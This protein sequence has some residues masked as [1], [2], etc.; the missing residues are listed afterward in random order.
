V[1][2][3]E[4]LPSDHDEWLR[5]RLL[6]WPEDSYEA[7][8]EQMRDTMASPNQTALLLV[9]PDGRAGGF[10]EG[11]IHPRAI[12][13]Q[14]H[15]IGYIEGWFIEADLRAQGWGRQLVE[16]L[17]AWAR[18]NGAEEMASDTQFDNDRSRAAHARLGYEECGA[19]YHFRKRL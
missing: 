1:T 17:E 14:T 7:H 11:S 4:A 6:M 18:A 19:F 15:H 5:L 8:L 9:R 2:I 12:G 3:R 10:V 16:R 13:C